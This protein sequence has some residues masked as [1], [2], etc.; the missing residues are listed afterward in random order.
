MPVEPWA[1]KPLAQWP[2]L[3][4]TNHAEFEG[5]APLEG[6]SAFLI[7]TD[8]GRTLAAT[9]RHLIGPNGGVEPQIPVARL[10][11]VL[12]T[13]RMYPRTLPDQFVEVDGVGVHGLKDQDLDWL[14]LSLKAPP[15]QLPA[16]PLKMRVVPVE[17]GERVH[18]V[19]CP[20]TEKSCRQNVYSG[21]VTE[22]GH[23]DRFRFGINP[24]V[25]IRGFSGAPII[26]K[27][28]HLVG[29]MTVWFIPKMEGDN[30][31]EA[32]GEDAA[33]LLPLIQDRR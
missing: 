6:A 19:G 26:D 2:Q 18:L 15:K 11:R 32:G 14:V 3:V 22:R 4:L 23:E 5:H 9:A 13:W 24:P 27:N 1:T 8:E 30:F 12:R 10:D 20:Y 31:L 33:S 17:V 29:V 7:Y 21:T 28:G 25:D 16:L